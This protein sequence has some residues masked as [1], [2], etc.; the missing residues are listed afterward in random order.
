LIPV[1]KEAARVALIDFYS[2]VT[3][4]LI[5]VLCAF[6]PDLHPASG[7]LLPSDGKRD[8]FCG[9]ITQGIRCVLTLG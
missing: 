9:T 3:T 8:L 4:W 6:H 5:Q 7:H 2:A 1:N